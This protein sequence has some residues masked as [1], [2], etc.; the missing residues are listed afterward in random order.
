MDKSRSNSASP[1]YAYKDR[2]REYLQEVNRK[3]TVSY[4]LFE[5]D[6]PLV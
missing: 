4:G 5:R 3:E 2:V 1:H 6:L